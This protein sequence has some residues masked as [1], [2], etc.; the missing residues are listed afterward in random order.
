VLGVEQ[1]TPDRPVLVFDGDCAFCTSSVNVLRRWVR[2][3]PRIVAWQHA[4]LGSLGLTRKECQEAVQWVGQDGRVLSG[5]HALAQVLVDA[6]RGWWLA[7]RLMQLPGIRWLAG[8]VYRWTARNRHRLPGG[9]PACSIT[10]PEQP[11]R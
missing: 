3:L 4:D 7:G 6:G 9:T 1:A 10:P 11:P 8:V 2:R 5:E